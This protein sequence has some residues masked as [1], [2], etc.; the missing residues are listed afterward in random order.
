MIADVSLEG[1]SYFKRIYMNIYWYTKKFLGVISSVVISGKPLMLGEAERPETML[2]FDACRYELC[3]NEGRCRPANL[4]KGYICFCSEG[5]TGDQCH[6]RSSTC[7]N[8]DC[9]EGICLESDETWQ[10][11]K[12]IA[13]ENSVFCV[14]FIIF[15]QKYILCEE[16]AEPHRGPL[17][18]QYDTS[19]VALPAPEDLDNL[20]VSLTVKP[21][22][23]QDE[24]ILLYLSSNYNPESRKHLSLAIVNNAI[25]YTYSNGLEGEHY[26]FKYILV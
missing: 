2:S 9:N 18:F 21:E 1:N 4:A 19:F 23:T 11:V 25:V 24:H 12:I 3:L 7:R 13:T 8:E 14:C 15:F 16:I 6:I 22:S 17:G 5:F 20:S 26:P 10:C